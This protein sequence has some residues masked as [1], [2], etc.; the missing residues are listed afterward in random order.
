MVEAG[1]RP[2]VLPQNGLTVSHVMGRIRWE[3]QPCTITPD[4]NVPVCDGVKDMTSIFGMALLPLWIMGV[5]VIGA[6]LSL[7]MPAP[8][9]NTMPRLRRQ[10]DHIDPVGAPYPPTDPRI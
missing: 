1:A 4:H 9:H 5:P 10:D 6:L 3:A 8:R 7:A 2:D